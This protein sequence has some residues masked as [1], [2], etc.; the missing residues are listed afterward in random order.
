MQFCDLDGDGKDERLI[1]FHNAVRGE[2]AVKVMT[3]EGIDYDAWNFQGFFQKSSEDLFC[4]D[5]NSDGFSDSGGC[6]NLSGHHPQGLA[7]PKRFA[8]RLCGSPLH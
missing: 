1:S 6:L 2:A 5:L 8:L 7:R 3:N 4:A